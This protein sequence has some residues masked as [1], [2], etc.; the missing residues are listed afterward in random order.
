MRLDLALG[1]LLCLILLLFVLRKRIRRSVKRLFTRRSLRVLRRFRAR[2]ERFKLTQKKYIKY[3]LMKEKEIWDAME[4]H[5]KERRISPE[6]ALA[7]VEGYIDEIVPHFNILSYYAFG[8][9]AAHFLLN[10]VYNVV[11]DKKNFSAILKIPKESVVIYIM[12]HR[13]NVDYILVAYMLAERISLSYAVGEWARVWPLEYIFKSFGSY[14]IRRKYREPLYHTVLKKYVQLIG[15]NGITQGIFIEGGLS[16]DGKLKVGKIG[17]LDYIME[18][19]ADP[20]FKKDLVFVPVGINYDRVLEDLNLIREAHGAAPE[21]T[22][23]DRLLSGAA[24]VFNMPRVII[25]NGFYYIFK[26]I[27]KYGYTSVAVGEHISLREYLGGLDGDLF[28]LPSEE[29]KAEIKKFADHLLSRVG[30]VIPVTPVTFVAYAMLAD[31]RNVIPRT[32]LIGRMIELKKELVMKDARIV[33]GHEFLDLIDEKRRLTYEAEDRT[34]ELVAFEHGVIDMEEM[35]KTMELALEVLSLRKIARKRREEI[36]I[37]V[38]RKEVLT[39]YSNSI[40]QLFE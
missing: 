23:W 35:E 16:R 28:S 37:N 17:L 31:G 33:R 22:G 32:E 29:K 36:V 10:L 40:Y 24:V 3:Q 38:K 25:R 1:I 13:S 21:K 5:A 15:K 14:F 9:R 18:T 20:D 7:R 8:Y 12:N 30:R 2:I 26:G 34:S 19:I 27:R 4:A 39:Y 6:E 11:V